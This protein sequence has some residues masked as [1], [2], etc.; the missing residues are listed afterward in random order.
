MRHGRQGRNRAA[1]PAAMS[2]TTTSPQFGEARA[3]Y[4]QGSLSGWPEK[5]LQTLSLA[6][7]VLGHGVNVSRRPSACHSGA[8]GRA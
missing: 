3:C 4:T 7:N 8:L 1:I 2:G 5:S 6:D